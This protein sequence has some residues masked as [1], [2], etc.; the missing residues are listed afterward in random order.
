MAN[1]SNEM[2]FI[3]IEKFACLKNAEQIV[4]ST[5]WTLDSMNDDENH[6]IYFWIVNSISIWIVRITEQIK[7]GINIKT[8]YTKSSSHVF[9]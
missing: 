3:A 9:T 5:M 1:A 7:I 4:F 8:C 6:N 2:K